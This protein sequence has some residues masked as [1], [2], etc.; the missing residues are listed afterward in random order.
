MISGGE[1]SENEAQ[2]LIA[3]L[4]QLL[5]DLAQPLLGIRF[6]TELLSLKIDKLSKEDL[7]TKIDLISQA[8]DESNAISSAFNEDLQKLK[9]FL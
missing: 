7:A 6:T 2:A 8:I 3:H 9:K 4:E 5:H 1:A